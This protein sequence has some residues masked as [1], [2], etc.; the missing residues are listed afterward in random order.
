MACGCLVVTSNLEALKETMD[1]LNTYIDIDI[2]HVSQQYCSNTFVVGV[3]KF[4]E[5]D[6]QTRQILIGKK[7]NMV[8][9]IIYGL[10]FV[11]SL[12]I[13]WLK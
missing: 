11:L 1:G 9:N 4:M 10:V 13:M 12:L 6:D 8:R 7:K 2:N 3:L 5:L